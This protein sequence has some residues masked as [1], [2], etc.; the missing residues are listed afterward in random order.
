MC[1]NTSFFPKGFRQVLCEFSGIHIPKQEFELNFDGDGWPES[2]ATAHEEFVSD[3]GSSRRNPSLGKAMKWQECWTVGW[4]ENLPGPP[5]ALR[6]IEKPDSAAGRTK[7]GAR[8]FA[9]I[10]QLAV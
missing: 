5:Q 1:S 7:S 9:P 3:P 8:K 6:T 10:T 2:L 4:G